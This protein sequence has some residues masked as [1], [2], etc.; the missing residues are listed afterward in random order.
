MPSVSRDAMTV[1][2]PWI[3]DSPTSLTTCRLRVAVSEGKNQEKRRARRPELCNTSQK[4]LA[5][6]SSSWKGRDENNHAGDANDT[7]SPPPPPPLPL[8]PPLFSV[9]PFSPAATSFAST[10]PPCL[11]PS[12]RFSL[13]WWS[14]AAVPF[15]VFDFV[16]FALVPA[17]VVLS[18]VSPSWCAKM[19]RRITMG[20]GRIGHTART[21]AQAACF[22][23]FSFQTKE[24]SRR[25][26][27]GRER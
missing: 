7:P 21:L 13:P 6:V 9:P 15:G 20:D 14:S 24:S 5:K 25:P 19:K 22:V 12:A 18:R 2:I 4:N 3:Q 17:A 27:G 1:K 11:P 10:L 16:A 23:R 26:W 8:P